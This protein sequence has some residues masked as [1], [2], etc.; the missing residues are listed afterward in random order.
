METIISSRTNELINF[1]VKLQQRKYRIQESK[2]WIE[3]RHCVLAALQSQYILDHILISENF[4]INEN[5]QIIE[6]AQNKNIKIS[7]LKDFCFEKCS[8][9][10]TPD[11]IGAICQM[12][13][14]ESCFNFQNEC[15]V[16]CQL[17]DPGNLGT[18]I[19]SALALGC[20]DIVIVKP[21]V[22]VFATNCIRASVGSLFK[23]H[24]AIEEENDVMQWLINN[25]A[26]V[27]GL[28]PQSTKKL[29]EA[30]LP[31]NPIILAGNEPHGFSKQLK[32]NFDF[33]MIPMA[34]QIESLNVSAATSIGIYELITRSSKL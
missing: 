19:R 11:G 10:K 24:I 2:F 7:Y 1:A 23:A 3:S 17:Q 5:K 32:E 6:L 15:L 22:D 27:I 16:L 13:K 34:N 20:S 31:K 12:P 14:L 9:M 18:L 30:P 28:D 29:W 21:T 33:R 8:T 25:K 26:R 4:Q